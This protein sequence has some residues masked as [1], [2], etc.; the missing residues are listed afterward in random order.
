[1]IFMDMRPNDV[2]STML[3]LEQYKLFVEMTDRN[4][5]RRGM[6]NKFYI[7]ILTGLLALTPWAIS[8]TVLCDLI[9][10]LLLV[11][12]V[13]GLILCGIWFVNINSYRQLNHA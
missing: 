6:T 11:I 2:P 4:S 1:M 7:T 9:N 3:L 10:V 8:T 5:E 13:L 12:A